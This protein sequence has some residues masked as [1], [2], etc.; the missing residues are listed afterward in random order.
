VSKK[1]FFE[2]RKMIPI[3]LII[4]AVAEAAAVIE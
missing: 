3:K 4:A 2:T 1:Y